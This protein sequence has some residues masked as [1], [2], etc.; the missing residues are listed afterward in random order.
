MGIAELVRA[1]SMVRSV[2]IGG[3]EMEKLVLN[4][5]RERTELRASISRGNRRVASATHA[6]D[7]AFA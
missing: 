5:V 2:L 7:I 6:G 3:V 1:L 4:E